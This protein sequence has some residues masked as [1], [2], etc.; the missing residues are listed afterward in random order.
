MD[1]ELAAPGMLIRR[2]LPSEVDLI[3]SLCSNAPDWEQFFPNHKVWLDRVLGK[4]DTKERVVFGAF[5]LKIDSQ[6]QIVG[7]IFLK[8]SSYSYS[9]GVVLKNFVI[10]PELKDQSA[11]IRRNLLQKVIRFCES[12]E[13]VRL[14]I[15]LPHAALDYITL[16]LGE[17]YKLVSVRER[18]QDHQYLILEKRLGGSFQGDPFDFFSIC[19]WMAHRLIPEADFDE[20]TQPDLP[21]DVRFFRA[22]PKV[23]HEREPSVRVKMLLF[24]DNLP[25]DYDIAAKLFGKHSDRTEMRFLICNT[26]LKGRKNDAKLAENN[27]CVIS[28]DNLREFTGLDSSTN[29]PIKFDE[30]G[31]I[32][33]V[34][35]RRKILELYEHPSFLYYLISGL[36]EAIIGGHTLF[37][38]CPD[39]KGSDGGICEGIVGCATI[40]S[41]AKQTYGKAIELFDSEPENYR[42][43]SKEDI[44]LYHLFSRNEVLTKLYCVRLKLRESPLALNEHTFSSKEV[45]DYVKK[46]I[47][48]NVGTSTYLD[49]ESA[50]EI[51]NEIDQVP[52]KGARS[53]QALE[54]NLSLPEFLASLYPTLPEARALLEAPP[55]NMPGAQLPTGEGLPLGVWW[56]TVLNKMK[57]NT[58]VIDTL[59]SEVEKSIPGDKREPLRRLSA[60]WRTA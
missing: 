12:R 49:T 28:Y 31:G 38:Y 5:R 55:L 21:E 43:L 54:S 40:E 11:T 15:E 29:L 20:I 22:Q 13:I 47:E 44:M 27:I 59:M 19:R 42:L 39:W 2:V 9:R 4:F 46:E 51:I 1:S 10:A 58:G 37:I 32:V 18:V 56:S 34:L 6:P 7:C 3:K 35:E 24:E 25:T 36:G 16:F 60:A 33:T 53:R 14:E 23:L 48:D 8:R 30:V 17:G 52:Y 41:S 50:T 45:S 57:A 26:A